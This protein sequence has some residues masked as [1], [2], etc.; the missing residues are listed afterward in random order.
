MDMVGHEGWQVC[1]RIGVL[2]RK[3]TDI[4]AVQDHA[5]QHNYGTDQDAVSIAAN[6]FDREQNQRDDSAYD[7]LRPEQDTHKAAGK[8]IVRV[9]GNEDL[10]ELDQ[11][12]NS[13]NNGDSAG[14]FFKQV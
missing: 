4:K 11:Q 5:D 12:I 6:P 7:D 1:D 13:Q 8:K 3:P 2:D 14:Q 9:T 10:T